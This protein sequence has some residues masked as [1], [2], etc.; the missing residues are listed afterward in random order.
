MAVSFDQRE[1]NA[2]NSMPR[3]G[4]FAAY[5]IGEANS[6]VEK[7]RRNEISMFRTQ[8]IGSVVVGTPHQLFQTTHS[9]SRENM[10]FH[11]RFRFAI[12]YKA[13]FVTGTY[14]FVTSR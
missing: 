6:Q 1:Q 4:T 7:Q 8:R 14:A 11:L 10:L 9:L 3:Q 2:V 13:G 5:D 12:D